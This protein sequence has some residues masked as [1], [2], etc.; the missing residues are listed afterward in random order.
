MLLRDDAQDIAGPRQSTFPCADDNGHERF[1]SPHS[2]N[3]IGDDNVLV[4]NDE[5]AIGDIGQQDTGVCTFEPTSNA[6]IDPDDPNDAT[7]IGYDNMTKT[8]L[9]RM[10]V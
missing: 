3:D 6:G 8:S 4:D 9:R 1:L 5:M 2:F 10:L 7:S